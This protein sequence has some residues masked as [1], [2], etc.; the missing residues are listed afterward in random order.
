MSDRLAISASFSVLMMAAYV[1]FGAD[2][3]RTPLGPEAAL[4]SMEARLPG[5]ALVPGKLLPSLL[6]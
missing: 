6:R 5:T 2:A 4:V 1:L 3:Q